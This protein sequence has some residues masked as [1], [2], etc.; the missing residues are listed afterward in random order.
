MGGGDRRG[1]KQDG[2]ISRPPQIYEEGGEVRAMVKTLVRQTA[3]K[4]VLEQYAPKKTIEV[5][6]AP[7][8]FMHR[9]FEINELQGV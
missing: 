6:K 4:L 8:V 2:R 7:N 3:T 1:L 9:V 5:T